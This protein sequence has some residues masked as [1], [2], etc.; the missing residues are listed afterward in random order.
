[1]EELRNR[2]S[3]LEKEGTWLA[4]DEVVDLLM[5]NTNKEALLDPFRNPDML[6][7]NNVGVFLVRN[8]MHLEALTLF[9]AHLNC[10]YDLQEEHG[11]RIH[12]GTPLQYLG[13]INRLMGQLELSRKYHILAFI[14]DVINARASV[15]KDSILVSP[16]SIVLRRTFRMRDLE[17]LSLQNFVLEQ[18]ERWRNRFIQKI[19]S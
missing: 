12:K 18:P 8:K 13:I 6:L 4:I 15:S 11:E 3:R 2:I 19:C 1:M 5:E 16:S 7:W 10:Y 17:L 14:E 9:Q